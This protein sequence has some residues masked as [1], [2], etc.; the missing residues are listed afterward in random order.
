VLTHL[1]TEQELIQA[2]DIDVLWAQTVVTPTVQRTP[3]R[4]LKWLESLVGVPVWAK[5]ENHQITGSFKVRGALARIAKLQRNETVIAASAGNHGLG[6]AAAAALRGV[7]AN[8]CVPVSASRLKRERILTEG[9]G[10][11]VHGG[12]VEESVSHARTLADMN[13]WVYISPFDDPDVIAGQGTLFLEFLDQCPEIETLIVPV[14]GGGLISGAVAAR[15]AMGHAFSIVGCEPEAYASMHESLRKG[16]ISPVIRQPTFADGLAVNLEFDSITFDIVRAGVESIVCLSEEEIAA[17]TAAL[18]IHESLLV[19]AAGAAS[20]FALL[21][22]HAQGKIK[23]PV[24]LPLCGGNIHHT[25]LARIMAFPYEDERCLRLLDLRGRRAVDIPSPRVIGTPEA[26]HCQE[27]SSYTN[28]IGEMLREKAK[29]LADVHQ[30]LSTYQNFCKTQGL[31]VPQDSLTLLHSVSSQLS[32]FIARSQAESRT[33][34][35]SIIV[36]ELNIRTA[37]QLI[38]GI[39]TALE[40]CS[41]GYSQAI[42]PQFFDVSA[43]ESGDVNYERYGHSDCLRVEEQ[44]LRTLGVPPDKYAVTVTSS[45]MA[46]Y[47]LIEAFLLRHRMAPCDTVLLAPYI[48]FEAAEQL[49]SLKGLRLVSA[50]SY[51][52]AELAEQ[53]ARAGASVVFA[54]PLANNLNQR[55][56][57]VWDLLFRLGHASGNPTLVVDGSMLPAAFISGLADFH[58]PSQVLYYESCSKYLQYGHDMSM[59]GVVVHAVELKPVM[60]RLRRNL[61]AIL[62]RHGA[63]LFPTYR[64]AQFLGRVRRMERGATTLASLLLKSSAICERAD[65]IHPSLPSHPD[66]DLAKKV[67]RAGGCITFKL[68]EPGENQR[69][70]LEVLIDHVLNCAR[71]ADL[72]LVKGVSFG[73]SIPRIA[74]SSAM[75]ETDPPFLRLSVGDYS[76]AE[77]E[78]LAHV[79]V[80]GF[81]SFSRVTTR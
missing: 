71:R 34:P 78:R 1:S 36:A 13:G 29:E 19:E 41:P 67:G 47:N 5:L 38:A 2:L 50:T 26:A 56:I 39:S 57:D 42:A 51:A 24:G 9:A 46:A 25:T 48:Y 60:D 72:P 37:T 11:I 22:L 73:F 49:A 20:I 55:L 69:D 81:E 79:I 74:A 45:G 10:L 80:K 14:G 62:T 61:G 43:Q 16:R 44:L 63:R 33:K 52:S 31:V 35:S 75:A 77:V 6:I 58:R 7:A 15:C 32:G 17:G 4:R 3:A 70:L 59:A 65:V 23:G 28:D 18:L 30:Q 40:W 76:P 66:F 64:P 12:T 54:D 68:H 53:A 27:E 8:V 21:R